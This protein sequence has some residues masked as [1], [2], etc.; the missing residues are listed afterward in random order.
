MTKRYV[1]CDTRDQFH[2]LLQ[3]EAAW[4]SDHCVFVDDPKQLHALGD[5][6][7][8]IYGLCE[9]SETRHLIVLARQIHDNT[10]FLTDIVR[11][12]N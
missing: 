7:F 1:I 4:D 3:R 12:S 10:S 5:A 6:I 9:K 8:V 11:I 2:A